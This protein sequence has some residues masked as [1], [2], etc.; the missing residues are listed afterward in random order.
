[1]STSFVLKRDGFTLIGLR[2]ESVEVRVVPELGA[3]IESL[4]DLRSGRE[5]MWSPSPE[6]RLFANKREDGFGESTF[7][8]A[9]ECLPTIAACEWRGRKLPGHGEAW[10]EAWELLPDENAIHT[11]LRLPISPLEITRRLSLDDNRVLLQYSLRNLSAETQEYLWALHPLLTV[12]DGDE[13]VLPSAC[14]RVR[15]DASFGCELGER[16]G[17]WDWP[18]PLPQMNLQKLDFGQPNAAVKVFT[19]P[20]EEG[21]AQLRNALSG[22]SLTFRFD[23]AQLDTLGLWIN[24]GGL[25]GFHH[26]AIEPTCGA[27]DAL[28]VAAREWRRCKVLGPH[29]THRWELQIEVGDNRS[30]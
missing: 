12:E 15:T 4:R 8:G 11:R 24:R 28:D 17:G 1:M 23:T 13:L 22:T 21:W 26:V 10:R 20:L 25:S 6:R 9:D 3:K 16:G 27:P 19:A 14:R 18:H 2:S 5:W 30:C 7:L 29:E